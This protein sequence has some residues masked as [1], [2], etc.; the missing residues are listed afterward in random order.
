MYDRKRLKAQ[1]T[2]DEDKRNKPYVD[3]VG[4]LTIGVGRNLTDKGISDKAID[5]LLEE[6]I[7]ETEAVADRLFPWWRSMSDARQEAFLNWLFNLGPTR[8]LT[9]TNTLRA[10]K[11]QRWEDV[12]LG[13]KDS[14]WCGQVGARAD[15]IID[16]IR[17]G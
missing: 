8:A 14:K 12:A 1:L 4:K 17:K 10:F 6:D 9:F 3:T 15:R 2:I 7:D 5:F 13:L 16:K 11:E